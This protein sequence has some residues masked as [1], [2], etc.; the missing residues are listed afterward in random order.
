MAYCEGGDLAREI[1]RRANASPR[2]AFF[3]EEGILSWL[4]QL[5]MALRYVHS[6]RILHRDLKTQARRR[7]GTVVRFLL[8]P[9]I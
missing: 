4:V 1:K 2:P 7:R 3:T 8:A 9:F 5:V 6:K